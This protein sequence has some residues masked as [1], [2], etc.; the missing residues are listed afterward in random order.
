[1]E[2]A[3]R[4]EFQ[5]LLIEALDGYSVAFT[6]KRISVGTGDGKFTSCVIV[7]ENEDTKLTGH[8]YSQ[9]GSR[10]AMNMAMYQLIQRIQ[11]IK[12]VS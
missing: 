6:M 2:E 10:Q 5:S 3:A 9:D 8:G 11:A 4:I 12:G 7:A 1:M